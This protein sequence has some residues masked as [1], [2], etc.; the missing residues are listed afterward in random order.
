MCQLTGME[1]QLSPCRALR[2]AQVPSEGRLGGER[3]PTDGILPG[4]QLLGGFCNVS[5]C[6]SKGDCL[7]QLALKSKIFLLCSCRTAQHLLHSYGSGGRE[8]YLEI[9]VWPRSLWGKYHHI[10]GRYVLIDHQF[11][12]YCSSTACC[13]FDETLCLGNW[14]QIQLLCSR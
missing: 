4:C 5:V 3:G 7:S 10:G 8:K 2:K 14:G 9:L 1:N 13:R 12:G 11:L 6:Q